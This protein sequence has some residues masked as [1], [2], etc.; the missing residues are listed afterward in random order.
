[1]CSA[2][3]QT[4][5]AGPVLCSAAHDTSA[6]GK[7]ERLSCPPGRGNH[8]SSNGAWR[9][10]NEHGRGL[11]TPYPAPPACWWWSNASCWSAT[12]S[13]ATS[14]SARRRLRVGMRRIDEG[15]RPARVF[16]ETGLRVDF[17]PLVYVRE[18]AEPAAGR[19]HVGAVLPHRRLAWRA[20]PGQPEGAW[21]A[22]S[23]I[24]ARSAGSPATNCLACRR[25]I[26]PNWPTTSG[27]AWT[28]RRR[29]SATSACSARRSLHRIAGGVLEDRLQ[30]R[31]HGKLRFNPLGGIGCWN[32]RW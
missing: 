6:P 29:R 1:M 27:R 13:A 2:P 30:L 7:T 4:S 21:A 5:T 12:R 22:T 18:F 9:R 14:D 23:S 11:A 31:G 15:Y 16:E 20:D 19:F 26:R 8:Q 17:G 10:E 32:Q 25:S 28:R 3:A 24:S